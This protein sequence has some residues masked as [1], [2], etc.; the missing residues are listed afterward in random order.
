MYVDARVA[1]SPYEDVVRERGVKYGSSAARC[2]QAGARNVAPLGAMTS[3]ASRCSIVCASCSGRASRGFA[4]IAVESGGLDAYTGQGSPQ[5]IGHLCNA[6]IVL[7]GD[8]VAHQYARSLPGF[9]V[10][11]LA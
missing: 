9:R 1:C 3:G 4:T 10:P 7:L 6:S 2:W 11:R 8:V 5:R